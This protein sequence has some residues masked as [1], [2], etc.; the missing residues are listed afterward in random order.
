LL[1]SEPTRIFICYLEYAPDFVTVHDLLYEY[2]DQQWRL[3][4]SC[5]RK[6]RISFAWAQ[7]MLGRAGFDIALATVDHGLVTVMART[8]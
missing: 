5:Y 6:C 4:K 1:R 2:V 3:H 8:Y 7:E